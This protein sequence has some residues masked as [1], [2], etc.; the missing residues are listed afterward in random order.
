LTGTLAVTPQDHLI[1]VFEEPALL[2]CGEKKGLLAAARDFEEAAS[3]G[4]VRARNGPA[5]E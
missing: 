2:S 4:R 1:T 3:C 5:T